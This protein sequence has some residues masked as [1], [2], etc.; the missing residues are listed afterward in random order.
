[1]TI[2]NRVLTIPSEVEVLVKPEKIL[3]KGPRGQLE[4]RAFSEVRVIKNGQRISTELVK[5]KRKILARKAR[6]LAGTLNSLIFNALVGVKSGHSRFLVIKGVGYKVLQK[7]QELEFALGF[8]HSL[9]LTIPSDLE[10][11]CPDNSQIIV[12]GKDKEKVGQFATRIR[13]LRRHR[14][15]KLAGIYY[16]EEQVKLR[17]TKTLKK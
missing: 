1:M 9:N 14:P 3:V 15:Y 12:Q 7:E 11:N 17:P 2:V 16:R 6:A 13:R 8:S 4:L 10:V 5:T